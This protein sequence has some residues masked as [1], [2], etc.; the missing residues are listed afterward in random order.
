M[1]AAAWVAAASAWAALS[2]ADLAARYPAGTITT[3]EVAQ[4]ALSDAAAAQAAID[5]QYSAEKIRCTH[6]IL[7]TECQT[8]ALH[9]HMLGQ[10]RI[11]R[12]EVQAHDLQRKLAAQ[13]RAS[14]REAEV[15][16][17]RKDEAERPAKEDAA[18]RAAK[19]RYDESQQRAQDAQRQEAQAPAN[20]EKYEQRIAEHERDQAQRTGAQLR[21]APENERRYE[22]KQA[23]AKAYAITRA[24]EREQNEK[25]RAERERKR[26]AAAEQTGQ[27]ASGPAA[28]AQPAPPAPAPG[29]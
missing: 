10:E 18:H 3:G 27:A 8:N 6:V 22:D 7:M 11:R 13:Q 5:A 14:Q 2:P 25:N 24:H 4:K 28:P 9:A 15:E 29:H 17:Q 26:Q 16:Q 12:V 23:R 19:Q 1:S 20:R 21:D